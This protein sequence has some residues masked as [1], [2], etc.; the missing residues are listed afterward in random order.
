MGIY[1]E[2]G[3]VRGELLSVLINGIA[4]MSRI[5]IEAPQT[6]QHNY[7]LTKSGPMS[8]W[9]MCSPMMYS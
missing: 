8:T 9:A 1:D 6:S 4:D 2:D 5:I 3:K 7:L